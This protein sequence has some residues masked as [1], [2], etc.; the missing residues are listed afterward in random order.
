MADYR[1]PSLGADMDDGTLLRWL[2]NPGDAVRRG[3]V[4]AVVETTKGAIDVEIFQD[5]VIDTLVVEPG[6]KVPV[7]AVLATLEPSGEEEAPTASVGSGPE[8]ALH[9]PDLGP[10]IDSS[11]QNLEHRG[12][13]RRKVSPA[14]R[15]RALELGVPLDELPG[16]GPDGAVTLADVESAVTVSSP[17]SGDAMRQ[18][19]ASA[20]TRS[21]R[22]IP[23]Y[24]LDTEMHFEPAMEWLASQNAERSVTERL[25]YVVLLVKGIA[26]AL[27]DYPELNGHRRQGRFVAAERIHVGVAIALRG[28]GLVAPAIRNADRM[29]LDSLMQALRDLV[30]RARSGGLR[31]S[32]V[33]DPTI[34]LTSLGDLSVDRVYPVIYPP[35]V[36]IVGFGTPV[37]RPWV[38][39][40]R[41]VPRRV[42]HGSLAADHRV[43]D[44]HRGGLFLRQ[45]DRLL[46]EPENL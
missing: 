3:D 6:S 26:T 36:A 42:I 43:S 14:A 12:A 41:V 13:R 17:G 34:T 20:M 19:I 27:R 29:D 8:P 38:L 32:E 33:A 28:G 24:Y 39:G 10:A 1:M 45:V 31:G 21:K 18:T 40:E 23:H 30:Q 46:Q 35:Q 9:Q 15:K 7:G 22:E 4:V 5:G 25:L 2:V 44:G 11:V 16:T 37:L